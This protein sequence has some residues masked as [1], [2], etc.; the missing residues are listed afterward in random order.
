[1]KY[2]ARFAHA[3]KAYETRMSEPVRYLRALAGTQPEPL[4]PPYVSSRKR[5]PNKPLVYLPHT[6]SEVTGPVFAPGVA[7]PDGVDLTRQH[8]GEPLGERIVVSGR[9]LDESNRPVPRTL[10]EIWQA[11][12]AGRYLHTV[13]QHNAPLDPNFTGC[14][15]VFTDEQGHYRLVTIRP[16]AYPWRNHYNAW[17]P[18]HIHFSLFGPAFATRLVT[19]MYFPGDPLLQSD[20]IFNCVSDEKAR[21]RLISV[22]DWESTIPEQALGYQF[23][24]VLRG[25]EATPMEA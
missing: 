18:A 3:W 5:A 14:G 19:Q 16:G 8:L 25:R 23:D 13:D 22:F 24:I 21:D 2:T 17:R 1:M 15:Q 11:N 4:H 10:I 7:K 9:V 12:A 20:P 6:I